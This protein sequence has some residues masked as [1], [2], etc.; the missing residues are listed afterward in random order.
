[1]TALTDWA[2]ALYLGARSM[3]PDLT[4]AQFREAAEAFLDRHPGEALSIL[5]TANGVEAE[6]RVR[7]GDP[8]EDTTDQDPKITGHRFQAYGWDAERC[9]YVD[10]DG[11]MCGYAENEHGD[12][13]EEDA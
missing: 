11:W 2:D 1:M 10:G 4:P 6:L 9:G 13:I 12:P 8:P 7:Y 3:W 5:D